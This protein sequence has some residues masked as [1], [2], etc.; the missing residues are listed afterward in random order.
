MAKPKIII[1]CDPGHDDLVA[2]LFAA[3]HLDL[4]GV[5]TVHG[6]NTLAN[7]TR[8]GLI[9]LELGKIDV[10]LAMGA[11]EPLV[12]PSVGI[13]SGHGKSGLD[14]HEFADP[15]LKPISQHAVDFIIETA[16]QHQGELI[17]AMI[18]PQTNLALAIKR[19][20]RMRQWI[21][22]ITIMGGS[23]TTGNFSP[24]AE[25]N[26]AADIEAASVV[27]ES[28]IPL[29]M[30]GYNITRQTG[31]DSADIARLRQSGSS[32]CQAIADLMQF[33]LTRQGEMYGLTLAPMHDVCAIIPYVYPDLIQFLHTS[34][35][36]E[37]TGTY[38]RGMTVCDVRHPRGS[39]ETSLRNRTEPN[40]FVAVSARSRDLI[41]R[42][43]ETLEH[44]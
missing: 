40:G 5:T 35:R 14:G 26:I 22:E 6:N 18:G 44:Y 32:A 7:T 34:I 39:A 19:E 20:P 30:V 27:F 23:T 38:T 13:A 10:P 31:F 15:R 41:D 16:R 21:K 29:R 42:V 8:N 12:Q 37:L 2:I 24:A 9:A 17:I 3:K 43:I 25:F 28:G 36:V 1:D 11:V 33:Y 4:L